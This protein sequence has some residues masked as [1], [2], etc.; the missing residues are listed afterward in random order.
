MKN[1]VPDQSEM[2]NNWRKFKDGKLKLRTW[3]IDAKSKKR[4]MALKGIDDIRKE[5]AE[6][7]KEL[8]S[9]KLKVSQSELAKALHVSVRTLQ[10]WEIGKSL[11]PEPVMLLIELIIDMPEVRGKLLPKKAGKAA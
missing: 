9:E 10:G 1:A 2:T 6:K 4:T 3:T 5:R 8:R 11:P 7:L